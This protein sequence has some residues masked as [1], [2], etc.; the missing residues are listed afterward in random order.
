MIT[1]A[2]YL[3][4][5]KSIPFKGNRDKYSEWTSKALAFGWEKGFDKAL[6]ESRMVKEMPGTEAQS[7]R[8]MT[9]H[10]TFSSNP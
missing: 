9:Q 10:T 6:M 4:S 1:Y 5:M 8:K 3:M 2:T 7:R